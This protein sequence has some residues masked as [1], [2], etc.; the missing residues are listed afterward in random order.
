MRG[1]C[2]SPYAWPD[3]TATTSGTRRPRRPGPPASPR[4]GSGARCRTRRPRPASPARPRGP[5]PASRGRRSVPGSPRPAG[6][7]ARRRRRIRCVSSVRIS[8]LARSI[9][10]RTSAASK[11]GSAPL[12]VRTDMATGTCSLTRSLR[13]TCHVQTPARGSVAVAEKWPFGSSLVAT[14]SIFSPDPRSV[15]RTVAVSHG[16]GVSPCCMTLKPTSVGWPS[17]GGVVVCPSA[18][19]SAHP[20]ARAGTARTSSMAIAA[21][22]AAIRRI[23][24]GSFPWQVGSRD[25]ARHLHRPEADGSR[26]RRRPVRGR[27]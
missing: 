16:A 20:P 9:P 3:P 10:M 23:I 6:R 2:S 24:G 19:I 13:V 25:L 27:G 7:G 8:L 22:T 26:R 1:R 5:G 11:G 12:T 14:T 15:K 18:M 17:T 21:T 4:P